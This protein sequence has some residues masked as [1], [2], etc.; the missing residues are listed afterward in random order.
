MSLNTTRKNRSAS[1]TRKGAECSKSGK[2]YEVK[3]A[4]ICKKVHS[5]HL[6]TPLNT[7]EEGTLGGCGAEIDIKL[8]WKKDADIGV[9]AKRP[10]PDWMQLKLRKEGGS[11]VGVKDPKIP[12]E[13][14]R[15]FEKI[16]GEENLFGGKTPTFLERS[17]TYNEWTAIK[18]ETPEFKDTYIECDNSTI[19]DLYKAKDCQYI[20][21]DGKGLYHTGED[22][23]EFG[24]PLFECKQRIRIRLK[25]HATKTK[26]GNASL[27]VTAAAQPVDLKKLERSPFS[28]DS[29]D[30]LPT[31]LLKYELALAATLNRAASPKRSTSVNRLTETMSK[32]KV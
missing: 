11:W 19:A 17:V 7:Q 25:V 23:C 16:I 4:R 3:I 18:K 26:K 24:V 8:N 10:T 1:V 2:E 29:L 9:E 22:V 28:L 13:S 6:D 15:I 31:N 30:K 5:P 27:S 20:Q 12:V 32:I 21:V 14:K